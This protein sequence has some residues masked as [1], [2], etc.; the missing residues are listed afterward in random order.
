MAVRVRIILRVHIDR[1]FVSS[2]DWHDNGLTPFVLGGDVSG[3][4]LDL[5]LGTRPRGATALV[6]EFLLGPQW[7]TVRRAHPLPRL[8]A[9]LSH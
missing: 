8:L 6:L 3:W 4:F 5:F 7:S 2:G 1:L 9:I